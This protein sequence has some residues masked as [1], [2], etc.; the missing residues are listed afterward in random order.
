[1]EIQE[2]RKA[3]SQ[4][5]IKP[6]L[7]MLAVL[8]IVFSGIFGY[9]AYKAGYTGKQMAGGA[10]PATV[11]AA[12][13]GYQV[14][15]PR[16][17]A[18]GTLRASQGVDLS[19]ETGGIVR[20]VR[21]KSGDEVKAEQVL[22][23]LNAEA[24]TAQ[25]RSLEAAA[26]LAASVY[27][28]DKKQFEIRAISRAALDAAA[29]E[30]KSKRAQVAQQRAMIGKKSI[31]APFAGRLGISTVNRGQYVNPGDK[32]VTLQSLDSIL[33]DFYLP[34]QEL[35][36]VA[37]NQEAVIT[38]DTHPGRAFKGRLTAMNPKVDPDT[39]NFLVEAAIA[40]PRHELL[41]GMFVTVR[42]EAG[43]AERLLTLPGT[44]VTYNPY[45]D[46][47]FIVHESRD[48]GGKPS[49][50][51]KQSFVTTGPV[52]GDQTAIL[53]GVKEGDLVVTSG[54]LKLRNGSAVV[55]NNTIQPGSEAQ[56][57]LEEQ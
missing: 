2:R 55:I 39:R 35:S 37:L 20:A 50:T 15:Q 22:I 44:A 3:R 14:W 56:P 13:A 9:R 12:R 21:F 18:V 41:P 16:V 34:Q 8:L 5:L 51:V 27:E 4:K 7:I 17:E 11:S 25:L 53:S 1:M 36:R 23:E 6:M 10:P 26:A 33:V 42:I 30:L 47:V 45:G 24:D 29:A 32:L 57:K 52:R 46:T 54:Q 43:K 19:T 28:R 38:A 49:L 40:N 48:P 31:Q